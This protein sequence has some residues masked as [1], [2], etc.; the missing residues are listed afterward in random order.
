MS[1]HT[2]LQQ[3]HRTTSPE[4]GSSTVEYVGLGALATMIVSGL[5]AATDSGVADQLGAAIVQRLVEAISGSG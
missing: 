4:H 1:P 5:A 2:F 3:R